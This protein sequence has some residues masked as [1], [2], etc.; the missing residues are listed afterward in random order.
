MNLLNGTHP[1]A[2]EMKKYIATPWCQCSLTKE[3]KACAECQPPIKED[4]EK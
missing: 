1:I 4:G 2:R 3:W